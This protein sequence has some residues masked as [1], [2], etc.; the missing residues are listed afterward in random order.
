MGTK[1]DKIK[2][3]GLKWEEDQNVGM[4]KVFPPYSITTK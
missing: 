3:Y 1:N 2:K 4:K